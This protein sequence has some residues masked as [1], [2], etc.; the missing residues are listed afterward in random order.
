MKELE[1]VLEELLVVQR[2]SEQIFEPIFI[3]DEAFPP[4]CTQKGKRL[5]FGVLPTNSRTSSQ[6]SIFSGGTSIFV[7]TR[8]NETFSHQVERTVSTG[9]W[10]FHKTQKNYLKTL[11]NT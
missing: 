8:S 5:S 7:V 3:S 6:E 9:S 2:C 1:R 11:R 10:L 4:R